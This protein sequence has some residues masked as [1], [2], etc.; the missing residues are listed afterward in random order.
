MFLTLT[1]I[2]FVLYL[3]KPTR[4]ISWESMKTRLI[5]ELGVCLSKCPKILNMDEKWKNCQNG[6]NHRLIVLL[7]LLFLVIFSE[8]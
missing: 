3:F 1:N 5:E 6:V 7:K 8:T 2:V 4:S